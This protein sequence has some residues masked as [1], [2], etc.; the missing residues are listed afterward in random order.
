MR[1]SAKQVEADNMKEY[2]SDFR[3]KYNHPNITI[4]LNEA[5]GLTP[6]WLL[7]FFDRQIQNGRVFADGETIQIGWLL[8]ILK[9]KKK[10]NGDLELW[11]PLLQSIP[12]Q[13][14]LGA[15]NIFRHLLLQRTVCELF[16]VTPS[17]PS[18]RQSGVASPSFLN[19]K[20][21]VTLSRDAVREN[22]SGW[23][24]KE[25]GYTGNEGQLHSLF[26]IGIYH[27]GV[28]PFLAL[29]QGA[30]VECSRGKIR[31]S[32][33][34]IIHTSNDNGFLKNLAHHQPP[35]SQQMNQPP[36]SQP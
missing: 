22:D 24:F 10:A 15:N 34:G 27:S 26:E 2:H 21:E 11:E 1:L 35:T 19:A 12:V 25:S 14:T 36:T 3:E 20:G 32:L 31:V 6:D 18:M 8:G 5:S 33:N 28:I 7:A 9:K 4:R 29:P 13:W 23:V 17:F 30:N 16:G